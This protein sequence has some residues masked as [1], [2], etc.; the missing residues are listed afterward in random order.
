MTDTRPRRTTARI[1]FAW[2]WWSSR[3]F[4]EYELAGATLSAPHVQ[5]PV[6]HLGT[7]GDGWAQLVTID[8]L[9]RRGVAVHGQAGDLL[10]GNAICGH[11]GD[12]AVAQVPRYP[13]DT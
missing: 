5:N 8:E 13:T 10:D 1:S 11:Q 7:C 2:R 4:D 6:H 9:R 3:R 12:E